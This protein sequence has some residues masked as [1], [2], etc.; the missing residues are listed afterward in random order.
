MCMQALFSLTNV[1]VFT[2]SIIQI[3]RTFKKEGYALNKKVFALNFSIIALF[4]LSEGFN[5]Y[6]TISKKQ[7]FHYLTM[8]SLYL[9]CN[10]IG[11]ILIS[12]LMVKVGWSGFGELSEGEVKAR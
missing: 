6:V 8:V 10:F 1:F 11:A 4:A 3:C 12:I 7:L 5:A 9:F 2:V